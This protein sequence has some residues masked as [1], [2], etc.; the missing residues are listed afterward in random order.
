MLAPLTLALALA[1]ADAASEG[2]VPA[3]APASTGTEFAPVSSFSSHA[4]SALSPGRL[5]LARTSAQDE[6]GWEGG[7]EDDEGGPRL[8]L[9]AW[10]GEAFDLGSGDKHSGSAFGG[11][12]SYAFGFGDLGLWGSAYKI[13]NGG[14]DWAPVA[15]L[16]FTN[17][18]Q[19]RRGLE[20]AFTF[21]AGAGR[22]SDWRVWFQVAL[23][24]R[25]DLGPM[26]LAGELSFE[27][28]QLLRLSGG[29]GV[30]L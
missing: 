18:F 4:A 1:A 13:R 29:L 6:Y 25:L 30:K 10:G 9:T 11:E 7:A 2:A 16:R 8:F 15:L 21:G 19:T 28:D 17:R 26:F 20:A 23:G 27:Q 14:Q 5:G 12:V 24:L 22:P 3:P